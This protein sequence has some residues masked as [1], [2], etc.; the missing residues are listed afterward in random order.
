ML[1]SCLQFK[2][3]SKPLGIYPFVSKPIFAKS[4]QTIEKSEQFRCHLNCSLLLGAGAGLIPPTSG[5]S[6]RAGRRRM[7]FTASNNS[8][9]KLLLVATPFAKTIRRIVLASLTQRATLAGL[10]TQKEKSNHFRDCS[11]LG[12]GAGFEPTTSGL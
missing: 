5:L 4:P 7:S 8:T 1:F 10:K 2:S 9:G 3:G 6:L 12:A 11:K